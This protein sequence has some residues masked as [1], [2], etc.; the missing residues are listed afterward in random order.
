MNATGTHLR[1]S[2]RYADMKFNVDEAEAEMEQKDY[3]A[4]AKTALPK[5]IKHSQFACVGTDSCNKQHKIPK[6][7]V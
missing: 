1:N 7:F 3:N 4:V 6:L 2:T 5:G